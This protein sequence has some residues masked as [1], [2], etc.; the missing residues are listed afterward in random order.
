M[1]HPFLL[2][3]VMVIFCVFIVKLLVWMMNDRNAII[4]FLGYIVTI[5][6]ASASMWQF[7]YWYFDINLLEA[8]PL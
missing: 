6:I 3:C 1:Q 4:R 2:F 5:V 7:L 8:L